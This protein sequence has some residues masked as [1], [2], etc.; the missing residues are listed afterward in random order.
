[1]PKQRPFRNTRRSTARKTSRYKKTYKGP[2]VPKGGKRGGLKTRHLTPYIETKTVESELTELLPL[3]TG[4]ATAAG[5]ATTTIVVPDAWSMG[6]TQGFGEDELIGN[7]CYDR[8]LNMKLQMSFI[9]VGVA[10]ADD[11]PIANIRCVQGWVKRT[12]LPTA[13]TTDPVNASAFTALVGRSMLEDNFGSEFLNYSE[14]W[15]N[16]VILKSFMV[17]PTNRQQAFNAH[18]AGGNDELMPINMKFNWDIKRKQ[19]LVKEDEAPGK[20]IRAN[21]WIPFVAFYSRSLQ[22][23]E[24]KDVP[25]IQHISKLWYS[26]S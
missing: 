5:P 15:K 21:S 12:M 9:N 1:M 3:N 24:A 25:E 7:S 4:A 16:L 19:L 10:S 23:Y 22:S 18:V 2:A 26:D 17:K 20:H 8:Y 11:G 13:G 14:K 6:L